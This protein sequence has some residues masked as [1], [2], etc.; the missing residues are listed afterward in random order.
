[1]ADDDES[2]L[3]PSDSDDGTEHTV[4]VSE[5]IAES[6]SGPI[7][8]PERLKDYE[9]TLPGAADRILTMAE[10]AASHRHD[11]QRRTLELETF[12][13]RSAYGRSN[14]GLYLGAFVAL[15]IVA[16]GAY[17]AFLGHPAEGAGVVVSTVVGL[18]ATFVYGARMRGRP[19]ESDEQQ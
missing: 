15:A 16:V 4:Q 10:Q 5:L 1:M 19:T 6:Y 7:P 2:T 17:M 12:D 13:V 8:R 11:M 9:L 3:V 14:R 18:A